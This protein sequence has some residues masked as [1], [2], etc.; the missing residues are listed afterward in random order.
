MAIAEQRAEGDTI[1]KLPRE[2][3][4]VSR[5][6]FISVE[7][8]EISFERTKQSYSATKLLPLSSNASKRSKRNLLEAS[9]N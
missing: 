9:P 3:S 2:Q 7:H 5:S 6:Y 1:P 4:K 8:L